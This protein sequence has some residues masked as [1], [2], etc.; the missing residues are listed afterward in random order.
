VAIGYVRRC[1]AYTRKRRNLVTGFADIFFLKPMII[2]L[3]DEKTNKYTFTKSNTGW[4]ADCI[5][6]L[7]F[8]GEDWNHIQNLYSQAII[9]LKLKNA[10][11]KASV[12]FEIFGYVQ[13]IGEEADKVNY[14][15]AEVYGVSAFLL[16]GSEVFKI[17][18]GN[19][20]CKPD[21]NVPNTVATAQTLGDLLHRLHPNKRG[22]KILRNVLTGKKIAVSSEV[23]GEAILYL[24]VLK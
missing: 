12:N 14:G 10:K 8:W 11:G 6:N 18:M 9:N 16:V 24:K 19:K 13:T 1:N 23:A 15:K 5:G 7:G 17:S 22:I 2:L 3:T 4:R 21:L 20:N